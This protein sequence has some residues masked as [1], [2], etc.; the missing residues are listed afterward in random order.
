MPVDGTYQVQVESPIGKLQGK[1]TLAV[2][3]TELSG[4]LEWQMGKSS[5]SG[6]TINGQS[7]A[8]EM[9]IKSPIGKINLSAHATVAGDDISGEVKAGNMGVFPVSGTR[10]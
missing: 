6:G 5:F 10:V 3:G 1:L 2:S 8:W 4:D 9:A 7:L